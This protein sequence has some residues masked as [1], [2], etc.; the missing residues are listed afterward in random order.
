MNVSQP[1]SRIFTVNP[2]IQPDVWKRGRNGF[3]SSWFRSCRVQG[4]VDS[5]GVCLES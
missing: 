2:I 5:N 4:L 1:R 3:L